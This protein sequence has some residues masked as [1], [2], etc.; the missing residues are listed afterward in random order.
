VALVDGP[1]AITAQ[2]RVA[3][4]EA[5]TRELDALRSLPGV[6]AVEVY[7]I[8]DVL[9]DLHRISAEP[10]PI[11]PDDLDRRLLS[12]L[13]RDGRASIAALA[14][15]IHLS[16]AATRIRLLRLTGT[17]AVH[18]TGLLAPDVVGATGP[19]TSVEAGLQLLA[20]PATA[21]TRLT[22]L[23]CVSHLITG[24]GRYDLLCTIQ[25]TT[26]DHLTRGLDAV[27]TVPGVRVAASWRHLHVIKQANP[28]AGLYSYGHE[29]RVGERG[30]E[31]PRRAR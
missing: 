15:A 13:A 31:P 14:K 21:R 19:L 27:R 11:D 30:V 17:G 9:R 22:R 12:E 25:A 24:Y 5:L 8:R 18:I 29:S 23:S 2:L 1:Y 6:G 4:D 7:R 26:S 3:D 20:N 28:G 16:Q 10:P